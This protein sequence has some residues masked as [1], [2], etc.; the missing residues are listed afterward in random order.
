[1]CTG[2]TFSNG[3]QDL[4][5]KSGT[6]L[7]YNVTFL[8]S[9]DVIFSVQVLYIPN[10]HTLILILHSWSI[11]IFNTFL[12]HRIGNLISHYLSLESKLIR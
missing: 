6:K 5:Q 2:H 3:S 4:R 11:V 10:L 1:M 12:V 8:T 9:L 7:T